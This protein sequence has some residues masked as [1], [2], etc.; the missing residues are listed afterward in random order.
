LDNRVIK[1][2]HSGYGDKTERIFKIDDNTISGSDFCEHNGEKQIHFHLHPAVTIREE[3]EKIILTNQSTTISLEINDE[4]FK[5]ED[6]EYSPAYGV[7]ENAKKII[8]FSHSDKIK[9]KIKY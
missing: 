7:K 8:I 3:K 9:W 2:T 5:I 4:K 6:Y 1:G